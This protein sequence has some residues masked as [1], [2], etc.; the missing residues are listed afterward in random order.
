MRC[1]RDSLRQKRPDWWERGGWWFHNDDAPAHTALSVQ[2]SLN[3]RWH[4]TA[5]PPPDSPYI[6]PCI[7][8]M[9]ALMKKK[10]LKGNRFVNV[11]AP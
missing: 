5:S 9:F 6:A 2:Y 4:D 1:L 8:F 3:K 7:A 10:V 11:E